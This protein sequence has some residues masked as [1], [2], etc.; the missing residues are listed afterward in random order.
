MDAWLTHKYEQHG[1]GYLVRAILLLTAA[2]VLLPG[3]VYLPAHYHELTTGEWLRASALTVITSLLVAGVVLVVARPV[4]RP[5]FAWARGERD[6]RLASTAGEWAYRRPRRGIAQGVLAFGVVV[7]PVILL[8][9]VLQSEYRS[10]LDVAGIAVGV[11]GT[12][13]ALFLAI[14]FATELALRPLRASIGSADRPHQDL[15]FGLVTTLV[16]TPL[17]LGFLIGGGV[18]YVVTDRASA[19]QSLLVVW[20]L[21]LAITAM[22]A[23]PFLAIAIGS[24]LTP[25]RALIRGNRDVATGGRPRIPVVSTDELGELTA[26]FNEMVAGLHRGE[27]DLRAS[28]ARIVAASDES[29]RRVE[30]DLHDGAQQNLVL[31][32]LKLGQL[33]RAAA[34]NPELK[35]LIAESRAELER[36]LGELRDLAHGIYPQ[37]LTS[38][39]LAAALSEASA[40]SAIRVTIESNGAG[41]YPVE[42]EAA[43]FFCCLEALQNASKHAGEGASVTVSLSETDGELR[44]EVADDGIGFDPASVNGSAGLQNMAD[45]IGA[46]GGE[47]AVDSAPGSGTRVSGSVP[48]TGETN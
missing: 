9:I 17:F 14:Y 42:I 39:G 5:L 3:L 15:G 24:G 21:S 37:V 7:A 47:L 19:G 40:N 6:E 4:L 48:V 41:R 29:R 32:N 46:L 1:A 34:G 12:V 28:R 30:R 45:R 18:G 11:Y 8:T 36:A 10:A 38:D 27:E 20:A 13:V 33:E 43:A 35:P 2:V 31:L 26:S 22:V 23:I 16:T 25:I 44:F